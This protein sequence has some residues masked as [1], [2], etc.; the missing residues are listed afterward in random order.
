LTRT[1][2]L[3]TNWIILYQLNSR[4]LLNHV[5]TSHTNKSTDTFHDHY[6]GY[7]GQPEIAGTPVKNWK[8]LLEQFYCLHARADKNYTAESK[9]HYI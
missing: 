2:K 3:I 1:K 9:S 6:T 7:T 5:I 4:F 8:I